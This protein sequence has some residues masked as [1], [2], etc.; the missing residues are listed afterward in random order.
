MKK[1]SKDEGYFIAANGGGRNTP[2]VEAVG[3]GYIDGSCCEDK[4]GHGALPA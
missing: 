3:M 4:I 1:K 2:E